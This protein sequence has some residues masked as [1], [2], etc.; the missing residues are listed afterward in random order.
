MKV[1]SKPTITKKLKANN[2]LNDLEP[3]LV[4]VRTKKENTGITEAASVLVCQ[5][6]HI[7]GE[8][9]PK[10]SFKVSEQSERVK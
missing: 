7:T 10:E 2:E 9:K 6:L 8:V 4:S 1:K 5:K 3:G